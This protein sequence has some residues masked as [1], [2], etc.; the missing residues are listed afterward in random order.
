M[1]FNIIMLMPKLNGYLVGKKYLFFFCLKIFLFMMYS[2]TR[3][4]EI[5]AQVRQKRNITDLKLV[6][7]VTF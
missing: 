2:N 5:L 3:E 7:T 1:Y 6:I 4:S